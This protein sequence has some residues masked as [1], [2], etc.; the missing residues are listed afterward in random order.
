MATHNFVAKNQKTN[1]I[2]IT[3]DDETFQNLLSIIEKSDN[4]GELADITRHVITE[5][6][7]DK[8]KPSYKHRKSDL[9]CVNST[10]DHLHITQLSPVQQTISPIQYLFLTPDGYNRINSVKLSYETAFQPLTIEHDISVLDCVID[11]RSALLYAT[12]IYYN[13][14]MKL[15]T[16]IRNIPEFELLHEQDRFILVKYN[17]P[18]NGMPNPDH[19]VKPMTTEQFAPFNVEPPPSASRSVN[20]DIDTVREVK[21][22]KSIGPLA[23]VT[24]G[25]LVVCGLAA[26]IAVPIASS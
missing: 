18:L 8:T 1:I 22:A 25:V 19:V 7:E 23:K 3:E 20:V 12:S 26:A 6:I 5:S 2:V 24:L 16:F 15:I 14:G 11:R 21:T 10:I 9:T 13:I 17:S 4:S